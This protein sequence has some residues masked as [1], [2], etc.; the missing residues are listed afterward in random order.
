[1]KYLKQCR[2]RGNGLIITDE[3]THIPDFAKLS[4][5]GSLHA[6]P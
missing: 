2:N 3:K 4:G 5:I 1:M 6:R